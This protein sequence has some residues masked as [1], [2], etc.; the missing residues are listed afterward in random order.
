M[1]IFGTK[2]CSMDTIWLQCW[3]GEVLMARRELVARI[4]HSSDIHW[5]VLN[6]Q[7]FYADRRHT[8]AEREWCTQWKDTMSERHHRTIRRRSDANWV[9]HS[10]L[11]CD[12]FTLIYLFC[13]ICCSNSHTSN[14][15][16]SLLLLLRLLSF[17]MIWT[18][19]R[20]EGENWEESEK[21][22]RRITH[23]GREHDMR[24]PE[25]V[26]IAALVAT[27][28]W[29]VC[30]RHKPTCVHV[31]V[32]E[33]GFNFCFG[34]T[35]CI[36]PSNILVLFETLCGVDAPR[37][38]LFE[39]NKF[40]RTRSLDEIVSFVFWNFVYFWILVLF[41]VYFDPFE[42]IFSSQNRIQMIF[43]DYYNCVWFQKNIQTWEEK[44]LDLSMLS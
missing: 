44:K 27:M 2:K 31:S 41:T 13:P 17:A 7:N 30:C 8:L 39:V 15:S 40:Q 6:S 12:D 1:I 36:L 20:R 33:C 32:C 26:V 42:C 11:S 5:S 24:Y 3:I 4:I 37:W 29:R 14:S 10:S 25:C 19:T 23:I 35:R 43:S 18:Y 38:C 28:Y 16:L 9:K 22:T 21:E 34:F